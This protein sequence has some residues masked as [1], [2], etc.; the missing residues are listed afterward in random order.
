M[1]ALIWLTT[2]FNG[3]GASALDKPGC[4]GRNLSRENIE[5]GLV[6]D[7]RSYLDF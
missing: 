6:A 7:E 5:F 3:P 4:V 1:R 2:E